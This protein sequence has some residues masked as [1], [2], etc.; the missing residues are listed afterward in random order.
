MLWSDIRK[1]SKV[2]LPVCSGRLIL[3]TDN[4]GWCKVYVSST[5]TQKCIGAEGFAIIASRALNAMS[6]QREPDGEIDG[7]AV[8]NLFNLCEPHASLYLSLNSGIRKIYVQDV[9]A[10]VIDVLDLTVGQIDE[11]KRILAAEVCRVRGQ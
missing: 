4:R 10:T 1:R 7:V 11:W 2:E 8:V 9:S 3:Q 6:H 5:G